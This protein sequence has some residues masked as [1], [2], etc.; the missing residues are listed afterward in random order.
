MNSLILE[1]VRTLQV[2]MKDKFQRRKIL[3]KSQHDENN[4]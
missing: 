3:L 1:F 4:I 2:N